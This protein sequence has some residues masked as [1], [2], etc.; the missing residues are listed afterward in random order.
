M[1]DTPWAETA[2]AFISSNSS[3]RVS[4]ER[5]ELVAVILCLLALLRVRFQ[6]HAAPAVFQDV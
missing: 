6:G 4:L 5:H 2:P 3:T 1:E